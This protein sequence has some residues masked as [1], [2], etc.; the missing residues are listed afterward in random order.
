MDLLAV[1]SIII[2]D[3]IGPTKV[4]FFVSFVGCQVCFRSLEAEAIELQGRHRGGERVK[5]GVKGATGD[6]ETWGW[7]ESQLGSEFGCF[8]SMIWDGLFD[9][10]GVFKDF[11]WFVSPLCLP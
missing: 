11:G 4:V 3:F 5:R 8:F 1:N 10:G 6:G 2:A 7:K 9:L